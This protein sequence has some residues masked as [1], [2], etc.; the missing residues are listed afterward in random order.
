MLFGGEGGR[1]VIC[2]KG[3][4][5]LQNP[6]VRLGNLRF[7]LDISEALVGMYRSPPSIPGTLGL[8]NICIQFA[9]TSSRIC[10]IKSYGFPG[11]T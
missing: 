9:S 10:G 3:S 7:R 8:D 5:Y 2:L 4:E 6:S 11:G 1:Q